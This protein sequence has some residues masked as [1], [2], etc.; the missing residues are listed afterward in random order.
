MTLHAIQRHLFQTRT[1]AESITYIR[2]AD[3]HA[4]QSRAV[5]ECHILYRINAREL[6]RLEG[7]AFRETAETDDAC[8]CQL[9]IR[10]RRTL[11]EATETAILTELLYI[12]QRNLL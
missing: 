1:A 5:D 2:I 3:R 9:N 12:V 7:G 6:D 8:V 11:L 10:Q 4:L